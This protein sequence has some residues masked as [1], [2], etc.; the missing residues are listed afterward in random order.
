MS[1]PEVR[2]RYSNLSLGL[3][4]TLEGLLSIPVPVVMLNLYW[5]HSRFAGPLIVCPLPLPPEALGLIKIWMKLRP[6]N[7]LAI[8][9]TGQQFDSS[10]PPPN[11]QNFTMKTT[12]T[13][14]SYQTLSYVRRTEFHVS[15]SNNVSG[16]QERSRTRL[17][18]VSLVAILDEALAIA[19][20]SILA[21]PAPSLN[22]DL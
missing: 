17:N 9:E 8:P 11:K 5:S 19:S 16:T 2:H 12:S 14:S 10:T 13:P 20:S 6:Q 15:L 7:T 21:V 18:N 22:Q 4:R 3:K 1:K